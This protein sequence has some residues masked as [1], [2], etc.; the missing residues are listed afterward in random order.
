MIERKHQ[1]KDAANKISGFKKYRL[2][3]Q[4]K[5]E[6]FKFFNE[7]NNFKTMEKIY[8]L[9]AFRCRYGINAEVL[10]IENEINYRLNVLSSDLDNALECLSLE[11]DTD[12]PDENILSSSFK[13]IIFYISYLKI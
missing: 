11:V 1:L 13:K 8:L 4:G 3:N 5:N 10:T 9:E 6:I 12:N 7:L 2:S